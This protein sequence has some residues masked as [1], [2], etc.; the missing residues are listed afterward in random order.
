MKNESVPTRKQKEL[1]NNISQEEIARH[2]TLSDEDKL[3]LVQYRKEYRL[4][5]AIQLCAVKL[6]GRFLLNCNELSTQITNYLTRQLELAPTL[7]VNNP[8]RKATLTEQRQNIL[9]YLGFKKYDQQAEKQLTT[10]LEDQTRKGR[11]P[12][13]LIPLAERFLLDYRI[14][15]PGQTVIERWVIATCNVVHAEI[16]EAIYKKLTP[17]LRAEISGLLN[18]SESQQR[19]YFNALKEYPPSAKIKS[20]NTYLERYQ[21][22]SALNLSAF[23]NHFIDASFLDYLYKLTKHYNARDIRRFD[24]YKRYSLVICF[25]I[26]SRKVMLD[27][28]IDMHDQY[29]MELCRECKNAYEKKHREFR[30]R[31]KKAV[32]IV[33]K[34]TDTLFD[35]PENIALTRADLFKLIDEKELRQSHEDMRIFKRIEERG[36]SDLLLARYPS[37]R[38]YFSDF[39]KLPF[40]AQKGNQYLIDAIEMVRQLDIGEIKN[41]PKNP[42][43]QFVPTELQLALKNKDGSINRNAWEIG[44]ALAMRDKLRSGDLYLPQSKQHVSFWNLMVSELRWQDIKDESFTE[45]SMPQQ[46]EIKNFLMIQYD[47]A[48]KKTA[49]HWGIDNFATIIN[50]KLKLK[51]DDKLVHPQAVSDLQKVI[52]ANDGSRSVN[53]IF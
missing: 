29:M 21:K 46:S 27:Y 52:E 53:R 48:A 2:W 36:Y 42:P 15:L 4:F 6:Y 18:A 17:E 11:L 28:L 44:L 26:E 38:K 33:L 10:W 20:I 8:D 40:Q 30:K 3:E 45:L 25:L 5:V 22:L 51:R 43:I 9:T 13:E 24:K 14:I 41:L 47:E 12:Q 37:F 19:S 7:T 31:H 49:K 23:D 39:I 50:G 16:F 32:D 34:A 1:Q 35:L